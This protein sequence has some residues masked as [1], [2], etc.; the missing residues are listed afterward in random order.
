MNP[1]IDEELQLLR[2]WFGERLQYSAEG[3]WVKI[4]TYCLDP[5][6]WSPSQV[7]VAFQIPEGLPAQA[8]YAFQVRPGVTLVST[9]GAPS[10][11]TFPTSNP[12]G[13]GWG[14][15]SWQLEIWAPGAR[16]HD[17]SNTLDFARSIADRFR[18]GA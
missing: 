4:D 5:A 2:T 12:W 16:A 14:T 17:G 7:E 6:L 3:N 1:R 15:F 8:P 11:Y 18:Q 10:N 9:G 13:D